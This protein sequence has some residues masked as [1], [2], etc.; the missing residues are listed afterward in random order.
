ML[1][2]SISHEIWVSHKPTYTLDNDVPV[3]SQRR[4]LHREGEGG[5]GTGLNA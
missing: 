3:F 4:A 2:T 5:P 1:T